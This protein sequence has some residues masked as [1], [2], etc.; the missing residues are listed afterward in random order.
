MDQKPDPRQRFP[1]G[2]PP[3][4]VNNLLAQYGERALSKYR[5]ICG[6]GGLK[7]EALAGIK[8][9]I[10]EQE[11]MG[12]SGDQPAIQAIKSV[13]EKIERGDF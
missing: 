13:I 12:S 9:K 3:D 4:V 11:R 5:E 7:W 2:I 8:K 1:G 10:A 6:D